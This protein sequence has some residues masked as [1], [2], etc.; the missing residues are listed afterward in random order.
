MTPRAYS[1]PLRTAQA[2]DTR[3]RI[4]DAAAELFARDGYASTSLARLAEAAG[5]S[6]ET[7]KA[8]GPK[9]SLIL[10]AFDQ[11]FTGQES[12]GSTIGQQDAGARLLALPDDELL[13]G[14][15][16]FIA[17]ANARI[18]RLWIALLDASMGDPAVE[19][20]LEALQSRRR[21]DFRDSMAAFRAR[22]LARRPGDDEEFAAALQFLVSPSS[23]VQLVLDSGWSMRR[24]REWLVDTV[25]RTVFTP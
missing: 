13:E 10:A 18:S 19:Q 22:G 3:R 17:S 7:V 11:A 23:Y 9:S 24:Y 12:H 20:G 25:E 6:L 15:V 5:V 4:L 16:E 21:T 8:N 1:S 2:A 14:W